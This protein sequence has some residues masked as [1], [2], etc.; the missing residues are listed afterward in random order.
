V[1]Q[2]M[3]DHFDSLK[4]SARYGNGDVQWLSAGSG[5]M[6]SEMFPLLNHDKPN[7][8]ELIQLWIN[9]PAAKKRTP[10][11]FTVGWVEEQAVK[12]FVN[13]SGGGK[14]M[15]RIIGGSFCGLV[16]MT[17]PHN[18]YANNPRNEV[19]IATMTL[20]PGSTITLPPASSNAVNRVMYFFKGSSLSIKPSAEKETSP[21][22][23]SEPMMMVK[24]VANVQVE[25]SCEEDASIAEVL[26]L[27]GRPIGEPVFQSGPYVASSRAELLD[28]LMATHHD[29]W[30]WPRLDPV[31]PRSERRFCKPPDGSRHE[32]P[33]QA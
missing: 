21:I 30:P 20:E 10:P 3:V 11:T 23:L 27:Q 22:S 4:G 32:P 7:P 29:T 31:H 28:V 16:G 6:H 8:L 15:L 1:R 12:T 2:G 18:S 13:D 26:L 24:L 9:L 19:V 17:T 33:H 5:I 14:A 25:V